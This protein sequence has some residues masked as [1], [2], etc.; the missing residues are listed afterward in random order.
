[1]EK[2]VTVC[3]TSFNRPRLLEQTI[4]SL[5]ENYMH[6]VADILVLDDSGKPETVRKVCAMFGDQVT[7]WAHKKTLGQVKSIDELYS[8][9]TTPYILHCED[10]Y[11][12]EGNKSFISDSIHL[13]E[14]FDDVHQV[15][16]R[17]L[18]NYEISHG[19][20]Y[21]KV[22]EKIPRA[23]YD[24][25]TYR[26]VLKDHYGTWCGFSWNPGLRRLADYK[27]MFPNGYAEFEDPK[28]IDSEL[29]CN[30]HAKKFG[31]SA[32]LLEEGACY[33]VGH[34]KSTYTWKRRFSRWFS[35]DS[36]LRKLRRRYQVEKISYL[37]LDPSKLDWEYTGNNNRIA[38]L[39]RMIQ[40]LNQESPL[41]SKTVRFYLGDK[42]PVRKCL[43]YAS[44]KPTNS[45]L[46]P[47]FIFDRMTYAEV[48][49]Y[50]DFTQRLRS[51]G[52]KEAVYNTI[53]WAGNLF[54]HEN[55]L[56][57]YNLSKQYPNM[58][59]VSHYAEH[60]VPKEFDFFNQFVSPFDV[61]KKNKYVIDIEGVGYSG[62][63]KLLLHS[64]R[65]LFLQ[66]R[67]LKEY[68]YQ[69]LEPYVHYIPVKR[70][71]S[72]LVDQYEWAEANTQQV[73]DIV[74]NA[75]AF[76]EKYLTKQFAMKRLREAIELF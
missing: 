5:L 13:L 64:N 45:L 31:Y 52:E 69:W 44:R 19:A 17:H 11:V 43:S 27:K 55:R 14:E 36:L 35:D 23:T 10:D 3:I 28:G 70:D 18:K 67:P 9:V 7:F 15:W 54:C 39:F 38:S 57:L 50:T 4:S 16:I 62:R 1:M 63:V 24:Y 48:D 65:P 56:E 75:N 2:S 8:K 42:R 49:D 22:F 71:L 40:E 29:F 33:N 58:L 32:V 25:I 34:N 12:F 21:L 72:N 76:A 74:D 53:G 20:N 46:I 61:I 47:D 60:E 26:N 66:E 41:P 30:E 51:T 6:D 59:S 68:Y 73:V 37:K